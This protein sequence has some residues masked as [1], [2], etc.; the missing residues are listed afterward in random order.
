MLCYC[1][2][3]VVFVV[4]VHGKQ[5]RS[6]WDGQLTYSHFSYANNILAVWRLHCSNTLEQ[7]LSGTGACG[8]TSAEEKSVI[9]YHIFEN[10]A[11]FDMGVGEDQE[12]PP[13]FCWLPGLHGRPCGSR[14]VASSVSCTASGLS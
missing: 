9:G 1:C 12:G 14:S 4:Y 10:A 6:C 11:G 5:L 3:V 13:A 2:C 7:E 8:R